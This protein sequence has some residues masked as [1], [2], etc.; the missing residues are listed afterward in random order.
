MHI[1]NTRNK[2]NDLSRSFR[3]YQN[4]DQLIPDDNKPDL[5]YSIFEKTTHYRQLHKEVTILL[6]DNIE[7]INKLIAKNKYEEFDLSESIIGRRIFEEKYKF[8]ELKLIGLIGLES[9]LR[10]KNFATGYL[11]EILYISTIMYFVSNYPDWK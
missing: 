2:N 4:L 11:N 1:K 9:S 5:F 7:R 3:N 6:D 10:N 8:E